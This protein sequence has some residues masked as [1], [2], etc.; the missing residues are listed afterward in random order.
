M[1]GSVSLGGKEGRTKIHI[2]AIGRAGDQTGDLVVGHLP[3]VF[4]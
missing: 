3:P 1:E 2:W 4:I